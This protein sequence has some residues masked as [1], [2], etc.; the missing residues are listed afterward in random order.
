MII[1]LNPS[2]FDLTVYTT[3]TKAC[4]GMKWSYHYL[5]GIKLDSSPR[6]YKAYIIY[7]V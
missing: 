7:K 6:K 3:M 4:K 1:V 5:K 2:T